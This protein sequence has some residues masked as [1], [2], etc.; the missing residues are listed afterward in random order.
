MEG[1]GSLSKPSGLQPLTCTLMTEVT[2]TEVFRERWSTASSWKGGT[3]S[4]RSRGAC[5]AF[6]SVPERDSYMVLLQGERDRRPC[7]ICGGGRP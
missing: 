4:R 5:G 2:F 1:W 7:V 6:I 3:C